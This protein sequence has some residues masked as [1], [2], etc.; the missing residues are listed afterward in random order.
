MCLETQAF[1]NL[2]M[3]GLST[4]F[5]HVIARSLNFHNH[6]IYRNLRPQQLDREARTLG[7]SLL[8]TDD[9]NGDGDDNEEDYDD[10]YDFSDMD[11]ANMT[12]T[13]I[14][15]YFIAIRFLLQ[16]LDMPLKS[17]PRVAFWNT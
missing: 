5:C 13:P 17:R 12:F 3:Y 1:L 4:F 16:S 9:E 7:R 15:R 10:D 6:G 8:K 14:F 11:C 2:G